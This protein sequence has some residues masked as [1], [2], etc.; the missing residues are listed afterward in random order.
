MPSELSIELNRV[1]MTCH[2]MAARKSP[3][4]PV[5]TG[6]TLDLSR[7]VTVECGGLLAGK[8]KLFAGASTIAWVFVV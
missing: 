5:S 2:H 8:G 1:A 3:S 6:C 7:A 4:S